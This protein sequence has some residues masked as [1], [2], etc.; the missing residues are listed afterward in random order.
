HVGFCEGQ[1]DY[2]PHYENRE[3]ECRALSTRRDEMNSIPYYNK[4]S[5]NYINQTFSM[6]IQHLYDSFIPYMKPS[7]KLLDLGC[8]SGRDSNYFSKMGYEVVSV[9]GSWKMVEHCK[10]ILTNEVILSTFEAY[11]PQS[12]FDGIWA[13][14]SLLHVKKEHVKEIMVKYIRYLK[15]NGVFYCSFKSDQVDFEEDGRFFTCFTLE[16]MEILLHNIPHIKVLTLKY[17]KSLQNRGFRWLNIILQKQE[18]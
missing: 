17:S 13:S 2:F 18:G 14:A 16:E 7:G 1:L 8:G 11:V 6:D 12:E 4:N 5:D 3:G 10:N 15:V 9:D